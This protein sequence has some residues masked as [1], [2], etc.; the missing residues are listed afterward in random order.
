MSRPEMFRYVIRPLFAVFKT[1]ANALTAYG[2][3]D[4]EPFPKALRQGG[5]TFDPGLH[6]LVRK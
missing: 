5:M 1:S 3:L 6:G 2:A 4:E